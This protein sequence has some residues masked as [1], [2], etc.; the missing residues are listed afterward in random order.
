M[1]FLSLALSVALCGQAPASNKPL[2]RP[3][4]RSFSNE[5][6]RAEVSQAR[7]DV[8][9][10]PAVAR[11][12][13]EGE[14]ITRRLSPRAN[15][16]APANAPEQGSAQDN[17]AAISARR[18]TWWATTLGGL[19]IVLAVIALAGRAVRRFVP[20]LASVDPAGPIHV[21]YRCHLAPKQSVCLLKAGRRLLLVGVTGE[22]MSTL[23]EFADAEE[24]DLL[25]GQCQQIRPQSTTRAFADALAAQKTTLGDDSDSAAAPARPPRTTNAEKNDFARQLGLMKE[26][27][28]SRSQGRGA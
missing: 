25:K 23:A 14:R 2:S 3:V 16:R 26:R 22:T 7:H 4:D 15:N 27:L 6:A 12:P 21:L 28:L 5:P 19:L 10:A 9:V 13:A 18:T 24:I 11:E 8:A 17:A 20:G 1:S